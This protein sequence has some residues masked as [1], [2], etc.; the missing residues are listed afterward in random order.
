MD[1]AT[2]QDRAEARWRLP[3]T[4]PGNAPD[5]TIGPS[6][7]VISFDPKMQNQRAGLA[8]VN[9]VV[10]VAWS[11]HEDLPP[12]HGWVMAFDA[13]TLAAVGAFTT[14]PDFYGGGVWQGGRGPTID[15]DGF[16]YF[17]TGNGKWDGTRNFA[18]SLL[19]FSVDVRTG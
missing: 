1:I 2:G 19:K 8:L 9:G 12:Y 13:T 4:V 16:A 14:A 7:R 6:G 15:V 18:N 3:A 5:S 11:S 10:L 17:A